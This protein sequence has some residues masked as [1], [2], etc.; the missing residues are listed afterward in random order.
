MSSARTVR[1]YCL[2]ILES[3]D[4]A[5]KLRP[6]SGP[7]G[8]PLDDSAPGAALAIDRPARAPELRMHFGSERL[9]RLQE[10]G[11]ED[12]RAR[13]LARFAHH[14]LMAVELFAWALLVWPGAPPMLRR[15]WL[16]TLS[17]EQR[18][19][20]LYLGRVR[21]LGS[22]LGAEPLSDYLWKHVA[23][24]RDS[25][26]GPLAFLSGM[27]LTFEQAN[28]DFT[29]LYRDAFAAVG[30][31]ESARVSQIVHDD[32]KGHVRQAAR[33]LARLKRPDES[34]VGAYELSVPFPLSA[35]RA[36]GRRFSPDARREAGLSEDMIEHVRRARPYAHERQRSSR[37]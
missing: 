28:L 21:A 16:A 30:D 25:T 23:A 3:G 13:C 31:G 20:E 35:A 27:G 4:L 6:P 37:A 11:A 32:E 24:M 12:A 17:D 1:D 9:P 15:G 36:K 34:D 22:D 10:L 18:H 14:E 26:R 7:E 33:W 2:E 5:T 8:P 29:L 19:L